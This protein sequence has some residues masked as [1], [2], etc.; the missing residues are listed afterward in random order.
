M[1]TNYVEAVEWFRKAAAQKNA[2][3]QLNL[4]CC[5]RD[6]E[7]VATNYVEAVRWFR[8]A[9]EQND[10]QIQ[11]WQGS[12]LYGHGQNNA[13][14]Q[15]Q[16]FLG[17]CYY[18]GEGVATNYAEAVKW[19]RQAAAQN[20]ANAQH[21]L[22]ICYH[23]GRG[24]VMNYV[25]AVK[26]FRKAAAQNHPESLNS[27]AWRLATCVDPAIRDG[28]NAVVFAEK[29]V[30]ASNRKT[31]EFLGTLAAAYAETGQFEK[32]VSTQQEAILLLK[33]EQKKNDFRSRLRLYEAK[34]P[35]RTKD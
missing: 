12:Y 2:W 30:A 32:A 18:F 20:D 11:T 27:L 17:S 8:Q 35:Y 25:E 22:G 4:G 34:T 19:F 13:Q 14:A 23:E 1:P 31:P 29:A 3:A 5:Y 26:W 10:A 21:N 6:G 28:S 15:A 16:T 9:A 7:G 33:T 24:V